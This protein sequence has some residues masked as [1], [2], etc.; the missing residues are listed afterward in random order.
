MKSEIYKEKVNTRDKL[1]ARIMNSVALIKQERQHD[2]RELHILLPREL[3]SA[4]KSIVGFFNTYSE[5]LKFIE[6]IYITNK[7]NQKVICLSFILFKAF[8]A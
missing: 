5:L 6:N 7:C 1:I 4:L 3:K 2:L 8:Y